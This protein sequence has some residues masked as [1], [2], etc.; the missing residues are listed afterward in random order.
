M[1]FRARRKK[2]RLRKKYSNVGFGSLSC[3]S[4]RRVLFVDVNPDVSACMEL[5]EFKQ[6]IV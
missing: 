5:F 2:G 6:I 1:L 4:M 3:I